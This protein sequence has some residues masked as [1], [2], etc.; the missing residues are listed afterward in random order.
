MNVA[1]RDVNLHGHDIRFWEYV[2]DP[3][4][5]Q[6]EDEDVLV[7][8]HGIAG[9][10]QTWEPLL[11]ELARRRF[12]RRVLVPDLLGH[13]ESAKPRGDYGLGAFASGIRDLALLE[14]HRHLT[15]VGHS[16][17]GGVALQFAYQFPEL[18]GRLVLVDSGGLGPQVGLPLRATAL[19]GAKLFL[20]LTVNRL[21]L[22]AARAVAGLARRLGGKLGAESKELVRHLASL[23]DAGRRA[24]FVV[25]ARGLIDLRGQRASATDRLYLAEA[26]PTLIV[27]GTKDPII[28]VKHG[29]RAAEAM[30]GSRLELFENMK[31]FPHAA[32]P[33]RFADILEEFLAKTTPARLDIEDMR[34][35]VVTGAPDREHKP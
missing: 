12:P 27:W 8:I 3:P 23:A 28:P 25:T 4:S 10:G 31:H 34:S 17:G 16:L 11:A 14:G 18:V 9:S 35:L 20:D 26:M 30:P 19:P 15:V 21:T 33:Q 13:G 22:G 6:P 1:A 32:D 24:A 2:P 29:I 7:L 5:G